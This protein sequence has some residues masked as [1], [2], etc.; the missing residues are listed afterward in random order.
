MTRKIKIGI[1]G[2]GHAGSHT[3]RAITECSDAFLL[4]ATC[5]RNPELAR[6]TPEI[7]FFT[8]TEDMISICD[9]D[10]VLVS[11]P[12]LEHFD[13]AAIAIGAGLD[14]LIE[15]P[16]TESIEK[17]DEL[18]ALA[19]QYKCNIFSL[20]HA[21][22]GREVT[23]LVKNFESVIRQFGAIS[24]IKCGFYDPYFHNGEVQPI[25]RN[26]GGSWL[27]SGINALSVIAR[28]IPSFQIEAIRLT[29]IGFKCK[30]MIQ[31]TADFSFTCIPSQSKGFGLIDTNWTLGIDRKTTDLY[32]SLYNRKLRL[33]HSEQRV[34]VI[35]NDTVTDVL[36]DL[37]GELPRLTT[38]YID[39][40]KEF[41]KIRKNHTD[42][43][44]LS[45]ALLAKLYSHQAM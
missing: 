26:L 34:V 41:S 40:L 9:L 17:F 43:R 42:N 31:G 12:Y 3:I 6:L 14:V 7:P 2:L 16:A 24:Y 18:V 13:V 23:W 10:A 21:A 38:H 1:V 22:F 28:L 8:T 44:I 25:A 33:D 5:D 27:D 39:T 20:Y 32:F 30:Q 37:G 4:A 15:K 29:N 19:R 35:E 36:A 45:R 11:V